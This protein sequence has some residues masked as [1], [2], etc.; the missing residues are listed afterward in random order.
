LAEHFANANVIV[1]PLLTD[2]FGVIN[3]E[4]IASETPEAAFP[5]TEP[6]DI[7]TQGVKESLD[8]NLKIAVENI[9][10]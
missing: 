10:Y 2:T 3:I 1:F 7:I 9:P 5:V 8:H 6:T 4:A